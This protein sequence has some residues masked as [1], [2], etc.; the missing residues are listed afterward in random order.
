VIGVL[1]A[2]Y[3]ATSALGQ[4]DIKRVLAYST[5]SQIG[6]MFFAAGLKAYSIAIFLL[7]AHAFYKALLFMGAGSIMHAL[8]G[9]VDLKRMGGLRKAMPITFATFVVGWLCIAGI[10]PLSGFFAK[11]EILAVADHTGRVFAWAVALFAAFFSALYISR[12][13]FL[14]FFGPLRHD[15]NPHESPRVMTFPM[16]VLAVLAT[17][18]GILG[19]TEVNG[20]LP[21]F[22][23]PVTGP[24]PV[25]TGGL[26][27]AVLIVISVV[28]ALLGIG[29]GWLVW[30]SGRI[31]WVALRSRFRRTHATLEHGWWFDSVYGAVLVAPGK[32]GSAFAAYVVDRRWVDGFG[33]IVAKG[34]GVSSNLLR[35]VGNGMVRRY[36]LFFL[37]GVVGVLWYLVARA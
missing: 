30:G 8:D 22:L 10:P 19:L 6:Y 4:D 2:L 5:M 9:E 17:V 26:S 24:A 14:A 23:E 31:D 37:V 28:V 35:R 36:A 12:V 29:L 27:T 16:I 13:V 25:A 15:T 32:A 18:G 21:K 34:F 11:D 7:V 33:N 1:T 3:G 20:V